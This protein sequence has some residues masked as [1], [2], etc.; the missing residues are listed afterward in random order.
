VRKV[1]EEKKTEP[2]RTRRTRRK[3]ERT[4]DWNLMNGCPQSTIRT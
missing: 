4:T 1:R 3:A 2:R